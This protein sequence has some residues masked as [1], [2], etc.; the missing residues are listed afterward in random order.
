MAR[1]KELKNIAAG[2]VGSFIS[3]NNDIDGY[4]GIGKLYSFAKLKQVEMVQL[5]LLNLTITP[6]SKKFVSLVNLWNSKLTNHL[7]RRDIPSSWI[8]SVIVTAK[9]NE[10]YDQMYHLWRSVPGDNCICTCE[11]K[12]DNGRVYLATVSTNCYSS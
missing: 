5:D 1:R 2:I 4:W 10:E 6:A 12:V 9:F 7:E 11:I 3:R 8:Q